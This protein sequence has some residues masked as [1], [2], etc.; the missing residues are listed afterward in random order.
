MARDVSS[1]LAEITSRYGIPAEVPAPRPVPPQVTHG[2]ARE[3][4][5]AQIAAGAGASIPQGLLDRAGLT[6]DGRDAADELLRRAT[7]AAGV[8]PEFL[9]VPPD[10]SR[11]DRFAPDRHRGVWAYGDVGRSKTRTACAWL[12]GWLLDNP[13]GSALFATEDSMLGEVKSAFDRRDV[14]AEAV[15]GRYVSADFLVLDD[16]GKARLSAWGI[17]QVFRVIDGRWAG[18]RPTVFTSQ[19]GLA[20]W[21]EVAAQSGVETAKACVSRI[22]GGCD[23]VRFDGRDGRMSGEARQ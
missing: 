12:R 22:F 8:P 23:M 11:N 2:T 6:S 4:V 18:R 21:G 1:A 19:H 14:D 15:I 17:S 10:T 13:V 7:E 16:M 9:D 5:L 20:E 3:I